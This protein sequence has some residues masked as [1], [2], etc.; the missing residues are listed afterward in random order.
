MNFA[1]PL[2]PTAFLASN[3]TVSPEW[4][5]YLIQLNGR[6]SFDIPDEH[7]FP[8]DAQRDAYFSANPNEKVAGVKIIA[9]NQFQLWDGN[10][11]QDFT[12]VVQGAQGPKGDKG[13]TGPDGPPSNTV[14]DE[15]TLTW[16]HNVATVSAEDWDKYQ[17]FT[18]EYNG[19]RFTFDKYYSDHIQT[20]TGGTT[21]YECEMNVVS[22]SFTF[23]AVG[24]TEGNMYALVIPQA[25]V[26]ANVAA[27]S[28]YFTSNP[29]T[30]A[31]N[32]YSVVN[33]VVGV[34]TGS[35][36]VPVVYDDTKWNDGALVIKGQDGA[37]G[38]NGTNGRDG[39][40]GYSPT[41]TIKQNDATAF[42]LT[43]TTATGSYDTPNLLNT[44]LIN[45]SIESAV[46]TWSSSKIAQMLLGGQSW[47]PSVSLKS[48]LPVVADGAWSPTTPA[49]WEPYDPTKTYLVKVVDDVQA[50][51]G[52]YQMTPGATQ[53]QIFSREIDYVDNLELAAALAG[54]RPL[55]L[56]STVTP[57]ATGAA[58][59]SVAPDQNIYVNASSKT[60]GSITITHPT[61]TAH[62]GLLEAC[63]I[64][65]TGTY[66][67]PVTISNHLLIED[68][69]YEAAANSTYMFIFTYIEGQDKWSYGV[70][71]LV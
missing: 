23:T 50:N 56:N 46:N 45:D 66:A 2:E 5:K 64:L 33:G 61:I 18:I 26:F 54:Y 1:I 60:G 31:T 71:K 24:S 3:G 29:N 21:V 65:R 40:P 25:Q 38:T 19:A 39:A 58:T 15:I 55:I 11:W 35:L 20:A 14:S 44:N 59:V 68:A 7:I 16:N 10:D 47:L 22:R 34:Y 41:I 27:R 70:K 13:D 4:Y 57:A 8:S 6:A 52:T 28:A 9:D 63:M 30:L 12:T 42:I 48:D 67:C 37:N 49:G 53:F 32:P 51:L 36:T 62:T 17:E 69:E 43:I